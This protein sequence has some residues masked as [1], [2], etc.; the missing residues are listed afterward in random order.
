MTEFLA[1]DDNGKV[2]RLEQFRNDADPCQRVTS[3]KGKCSN[4]EKEADAG[5]FCFGCRQLICWDCFEEESHFSACLN[6][7]A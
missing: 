6:T 1:L 3:D 4:C 7:Q 5:D 2:A